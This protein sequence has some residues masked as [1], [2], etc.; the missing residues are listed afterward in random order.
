[1]EGKWVQRGEREQNTREVTRNS[2][3]EDEE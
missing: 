2:R 3:A 1:M